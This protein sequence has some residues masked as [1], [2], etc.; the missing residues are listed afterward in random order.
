MIKQSKTPADSDNRQN[1]LVKSTKPQE[2]ERD[3]KLSRKDAMGGCPADV[4]VAGEE[5]AGVG[6]EFLVNKADD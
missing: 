1:T 2:H 4:S 5:D 3:L 6:L